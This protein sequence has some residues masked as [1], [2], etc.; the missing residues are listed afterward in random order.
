MREMLRVQQQREA[1]FDDDLASERR[2]VVEAR[3]TLRAVREDVALQEDTARRD[4]DRARVASIG[5][6]RAAR[7]PGARFTARARP[8]R[9]TRRQGPGRAAG[10]GGPARRPDRGVGCRAR[11]RRRR[12]QRP[13]DPRR[14][15]A[16]RR[17]C[18]RAFSASSANG[19]GS[20]RRFASAARR[21]APCDATRCAWSARPS[22]FGWNSGR[23]AASRWISSMPS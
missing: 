12:R 17:S 10:T 13:W 3:A 5:G 20:N 9:G 19:A 22:G 18:G 11:P 4:A 2:R 14:R 21:C 16:A 6:G 1:A 23:R 8:P 7:G 15:V